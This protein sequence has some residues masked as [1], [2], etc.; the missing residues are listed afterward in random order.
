MA[1][2]GSDKNFIQKSGFDTQDILRKPGNLPI[3]IVYEE[4]RIYKCVV[5]KRCRK[6]VENVQI[7]TVFL[8]G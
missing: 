7:F 3:D 5:K 1:E 2:S 6:L 8:T 4:K